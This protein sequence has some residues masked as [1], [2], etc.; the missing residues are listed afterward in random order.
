ML[1]KIE[2]HPG[3]PFVAAVTIGIQSVVFHRLLLL[4][5]CLELLNPYSRFHEAL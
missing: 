5:A 3:L 1:M 4:Q 2:T